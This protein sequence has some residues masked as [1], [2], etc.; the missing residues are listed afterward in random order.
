MSVQ[1]RLAEVSDAEAM[2][3]I[4]APIVRATAVSFELEPPTIAAFRE[5]IATYTRTAPWLVCQIDGGVAGY[6]YAAPFRPRPAYQWTVEVTVYVAVG[7]RRRG[8]AR[9]LY[10]ALLELLRMQGFVTVVGIIALPNLE[11]VALHESLGFELVGIFR[12]IGFKLGAWHDTGW[13]VKPLQIGAMVPADLQN[14]ATVVNTAD[15]KEL[16]SSVAS[17]IRSGVRH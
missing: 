10:T 13:W 17:L 5:R 1:I 2:L 15:A 7:F 12:R 8:I 11:S 14:P 3:D 6:A 4:Y 16:F 9:G